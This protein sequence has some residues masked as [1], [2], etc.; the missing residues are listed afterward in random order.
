MIEHNFT[1]LFTAVY[2]PLT[3]TV[4]LCPVSRSVLENSS[5]YRGSSLFGHLTY[6]NIGLGV[7]KVAIAA[8]HSAM[9]RNNVLS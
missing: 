7:T 3:A 4:Q 9:Y 1:N 5:H 2:V 8:I 6:Q